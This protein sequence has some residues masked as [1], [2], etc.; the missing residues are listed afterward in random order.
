MT[1][2][3]TV[4]PS[5]T[6]VPMYSW[7]GVKFL[8]NGG[9]PPMTAGGP[10]PITS[11]SVAQIATAS[12]RM[13]TSATP[14]MGT[15]LSTRLS[16]P[17]SPS[18]HVF[19]TFIFFLGSIIR[20]RG[21]KSTGAGAVAWKQGVYNLPFDY[22]VSQ[23]QPLMNL[24]RLVCRTV[25]VLALPLIA[26]AQDTTLSGTVRDNTGGVLPG[27]TVTATSEAQGTTFVGVTDERGLYRIVVRPGVFRVS[28]ELAGF[29]TPQRP[30]TEILL[31][32]AVTL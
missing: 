22:V 31:G 18:T 1:N 32:R 2:S 26:L 12:I 6:I 8:L 11:R 5:P 13:S 20:F 3:S 9:S 21:P 25:P 23:K 27:V 28:A 15:G 16:W 30:G 4:G 19:I 7:P 29:T 24:G 14:G 17:G 10:W